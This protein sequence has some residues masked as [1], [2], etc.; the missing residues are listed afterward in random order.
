MKDR[1]RARASRIW[2]TA[3]V[4]LTLALGLV[5]CTGSWGDLV[6]I[7]PTSRPA[8]VAPGESGSGSTIEQAVFVAVVDGDTITTTAGTVRLIGIDTPERGQ[9]GHGGASAAIGRL[10]SRD[11]P[12]TLELPAGENDQ[13]RHGRLLRYV[14]TP[15]G[16]DLG[17]MQLESGNA[18][19]RYDS[20][21][22]Y[23]AHPREADYHAAQIAALGADG[24]VVP[25]SCRAGDTSPAPSSSTT[26]AWWERYTS[27]GKLKRN[28]NG[29]PTGPFHRDDPAEAEIYEWFAHRTGNNGDGDGDGLAC[30]G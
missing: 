16:V 12:V 29:D 1:Q 11:D 3:G 13:D 20:T 26:G 25:T 5:G 9:C 30:E 10:L 19:A 27:C 2:R 14:T 23:P 24:T 17:L 28:T 22:G 8:T 15:A 4:A 21:D 18:V 7:P 6:P